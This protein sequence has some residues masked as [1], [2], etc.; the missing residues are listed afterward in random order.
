MTSTSPSPASP[1]DAGKRRAAMPFIMITVLIDM[2]SIGLIIPVLPALVGS[3]TASQT[4]QAWWYG[5]VTFAFSFANFISS[6][7]LGALSDRFGRRPVLLWGL[8]GYVAASIGGAMAPSIE[9]LIVWRALQGGQLDDLER[10][11]QD[12]LADDDRPINSGSGTE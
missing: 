10:P 7:V 4:E 9:I 3:F 12:L 2:V 5:A 1:G 6:P 11:S 8:G